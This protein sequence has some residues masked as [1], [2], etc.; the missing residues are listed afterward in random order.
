MLFKKRLNNNAVVA[1]DDASVEQILIGRGLGFQIVVGSEVDPAK[2]EK[3]FV[4]KDHSAAQQLQQLLEAIPVDYVDLA[5]RVYR[6]AKQN[7]SIPISESVI[8]HLADHIYMAVNRIQQ[9]IEIK[10]MM[11]PTIQRFYRDEYQI[12]GHAVELA[13]R[14]FGVDFTA[15]EA[16]FIALHLVNAQLGS[17]DS[18]ASLTKITT[19]VEE[20]ERIVRMQFTMNFDTDS[21]QYRRFITHCTFFAERLFQDTTHRTGDV[22]RALE[23]IRASYP[24][25]ATCVRKIGEFL[26]T[27]YHHQLTGEETLYLTIHIAQMLS[28]SR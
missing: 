1:I 6:Y 13:N 16:G 7:L 22:E 10:N 28:A 21:V 24:E 3:A 14:E 27:K 20:I 5:E 17:G 25:A 8:V 9:G 26:E 2:V 15:D 18:T 12:G 23:T 19:V 11:L 4:L